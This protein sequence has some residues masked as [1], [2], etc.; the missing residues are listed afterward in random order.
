MNRF[1]GGK[2]GWAWLSA[3]LSALLQAA[4]LVHFTALRIRTLVERSVDGSRE[5][6][7]FA[8]M[9]RFYEKVEPKALKKIRI[10]AGTK[11]VWDREPLLW[12]E[13]RTSAA[14][15]FRT[16]VRAALIGLILLILPLSCLFTNASERGATL[17]VGLWVG[18]I[19]LLL[20]SAGAGVN[21]FSLEKEER[22]WDI[23]LT[24]PLSAAEILFAKLAANLVG[25]IPIAGLLTVFWTLVCLFYSGS[26]LGW[27]FILLVAALPCLLA[28]VMGALASLKAASARG[29]ST[30]AFSSV[31]VGYFLLPVIALLVLE[32]LRFGRGARWI[33]PED[34]I[35][36]IN[37]AIYLGEACEWIGR[38]G[39]DWGE[40]RTLD[41]TVFRN[42]GGQA[43]VYLLLHGA[44]IAGVLTA[45]Y[46][47]LRRLG[48]RR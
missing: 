28:Y 31:L 15:S 30:V 45:I 24:T 18:A 7:P 8:A 25:L 26:P 29:A 46:A 44:F 34:L 36:L 20:R 21:A 1:L 11:R 22:K 9:D 40:R 5:S 37:P 32:F 48:N 35:A 23:L 16:A 43:L 2:F 12:K 38:Q 27:F 10:F 42:R 17:I 19:S 6:K 3:T 41:G 47:A 14:G 4:L 33:D 13:L 39:R